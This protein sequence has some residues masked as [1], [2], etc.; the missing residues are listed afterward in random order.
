MGFEIGFLLLFLSVAFFHNLS[1][2]FDVDFL[3]FSLLRHLLISVCVNVIHAKYNGKI[4]ILEKEKSLSS[5][6]P[7]YR[8][9]LSTYSKSIMSLYDPLCME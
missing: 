6:I 4:R 8:L 1:S 3:Q 5:K 7:P 9:H 2:E